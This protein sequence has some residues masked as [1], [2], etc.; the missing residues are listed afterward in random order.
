MVDYYRSKPPSPGSRTF[1]LPTNIAAS[2]LVLKER[3]ELSTPKKRYLR[4]PCLPIPPFQHIVFVYPK[5]QAS[6][7]FAILQKEVSSMVKWWAGLGSNQ[8]SRS[9]W[10]TVRPATFYGIPTHILRELG[11]RQ[12]LWRLFTVTFDRL[13]NGTTYHRGLFMGYRPICFVI[14]GYASPTLTMYYHRGSEGLTQFPHSDFSFVR[15]QTPSFLWLT[16]PLTIGNI[17]VSLSFMG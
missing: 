1:C 7:R 14:I 17:S 3:L 9:T 12:S 16:K 10:F 6:F 8:P 11:Q 13:F 15:E 5:C 2:G 4:P